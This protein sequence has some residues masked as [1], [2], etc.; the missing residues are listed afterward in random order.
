MQLE[1]KRLGSECQSLRGERE[2]KV[3]ELEG[4]LAAK[5]SQHGAE[6]ETLC[7]RIGELEQNNRGRCVSFVLLVKM[8]DIV[9]VSPRSQSLILSQ[10][11]HTAYQQA[12]VLS[13]SF[14]VKNRH[15]AY[16]QAL[17]LSLNRTSFSV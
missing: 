3:V 9:G 17:V 13:L 7:A 16:Q 8:Q 4:A 14:S 2:A 15:T 6:M 10:N 5:E 12:L 11:K 1:A